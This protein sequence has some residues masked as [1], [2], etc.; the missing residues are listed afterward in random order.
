MFTSHL[1]GPAAQFA[2]DDPLSIA[3]RERQLAL[4]QSGTG[5]NRDRWRR[6]LPI[7][8]AISARHQVQSLVYA[9]TAVAIS[10]TT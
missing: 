7:D 9:V 10:R 1:V 5:S 8:C 2:H 4:A 3:N 6:R